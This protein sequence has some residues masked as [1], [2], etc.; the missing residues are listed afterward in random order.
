MNV[1]RVP[2]GPYGPRSD[3]STPVRHPSTFPQ[4]NPQQW[5]GSTPAAAR[6]GISVGHLYR[7]VAAGHLHQY[8]PEGAHPLFWVP[9]LD[10]YRR[11]RRARD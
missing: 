11:S 2:R 7:L 10:A 6:L 8:R 1:L 5:C 3:R 4:P 9:E